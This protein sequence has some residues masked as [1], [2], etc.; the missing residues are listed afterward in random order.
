MRL[1]KYIA[2]CGYCSRRHAELLI[3]A[4]LVRVNG[5]PVPP[6]GIAIAPGRDRVTIH[7]DEVVPAPRTTIAL[8]K[9][10]GFISSTHDTH[11]RLTVMDLLPRRM[12]EW[13]V[14][15]VGRLD[16]DTEGLL[17]LTN[18][19]DLAHRLT[20]PRYECEKEYRA[21]VEGRV[22]KEARRRL[23]EDDRLVQGMT[24]PV[25]ITAVRD[26]GDRS[27]VRI[28]LRE[29]LKRQIRLM[30]RAV[31]HE[32]LE[33][34]RIRIGGLTLGDLPRGGWRELRPEEVDLCVEDGGSA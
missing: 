11:E 31:G 27:E 4:G 17:L 24:R 20:H 23:V 19:G 16:L 26:L 32:V 6:A 10:V 5:R 7:G 21:L 25:R 34:E 29:G 8:N 9:P 30:L 3:A 28:V 14:F 12:R 1:H 13:G 15:P 33:L 2:N 22:G 18:V